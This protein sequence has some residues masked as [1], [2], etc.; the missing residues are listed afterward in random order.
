MREK[1]TVL[2]L[3]P[4][5]IAANFG[6]ETFLAHVE[7]EVPER[8]TSEQKQ[9]AGLEAAKLGQHEAGE[10]YDRTPE[11]AE[12]EFYVLFVCDGWR[13]DELHEERICMRLPLTEKEA[14]LIR[15]LAETHLNSTGSNQRAA[16]CNTGL[17][18]LNHNPMS[19][20]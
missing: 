9:A 16:V 1:F 3:V 12:Q 2:T 14:R 4:D 20:L 19:R 6:H 8:W 10:F 7:V 13:L 18:K 15:Y 5:T 11:E 17:Q